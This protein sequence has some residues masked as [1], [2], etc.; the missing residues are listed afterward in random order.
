MDWMFLSFP[1]SYVKDLIKY[2]VAV[3]EGRASK[4]VTEVKW[5]QMRSW[6]CTEERSRE[7]V[8]RGC[9]QYARKTVL[10][11]NQIG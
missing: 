8:A 4:E 11:R 1:K 7:D 10:T 2:S 3:F 9:C 5:D 6:G